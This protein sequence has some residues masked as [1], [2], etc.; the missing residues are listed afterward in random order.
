MAA[1]QK[2]K[3]A[4]DEARYFNREL[5]WLV[6]NT[7]VLEEALVE[8]TPLL[9]RLKFVAIVASNLDEFFMVRVGGLKLLAARNPRHRDFAGLSPAQQLDA[10]RE[11]AREQVGQ[12]DACYQN[13]LEPRLAAAGIRR[14][15]AAD[16]T[17]GQRAYAERFMQEEVLSVLTP[18]AVQD[19]QALPLLA[20]KRLHL[21][22]RLKAETESDA[23]KFAVIPISAAL[24]RFITL[25]STQDFEYILIEDLIA[26]FIELFFPGEK[27]M[28][29]VAFRPTR[30]AD[31]SVREDMAADLLSHMK[32]VLDARDTSDC[33]RLELDARAT[34]I[35]TRFLRQLLGVRDHDIYC[36]KGPLDL[37]AMMKIAGLGGY[38]MLRQEPWR[39]VLPV[40]TPEGANMFELLDRG[41]ILLYHPYDA[42][43]PVLRLLHQAADDP[44]VLAIKQILYRT[45]SNSQI[46]KALLRAA[47]NGKHVTALVE[48]KARFDEARNIDRARDLEHAGVQV[49]YGVKG[50]KTHAKLCLV[51][52]REPSGIARYLHLGTGNYNENTASLYSDVSFLVKDP[53]L[54][55]DAAMF[56]NAI[57]GYSQPQNYEKI[58]AAPT[59]LRDRLLQGIDTEI[60]FA[61]QG[62]AA[63]IWAKVN[64]LAD[65]VMI[66]KLYEASRAGVKIELNIRGICCLRPGVSGLSENIRVLSIIDRYLEHARIIYFHHGGEPRI[67]ISSADWM[68][69][70]LDRRIELLAP[71]EP[72]ECRQRLIRILKMHFSDNV[73]GRELQPDGS[74]RMP[75]MKKKGRRVQS[76]QVLHGE[77]EEASRKARQLETTVFEPHLPPTSAA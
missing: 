41:P 3:S 22:V 51:V 27:V 75:P 70:N 2:K 58:A 73:K 28:E 40:A 77:V 60:E 30:N 37:S 43:E 66:D 46:V 62:Q 53:I 50:Y 10:I 55:Q 42:F 16:L 65:P 36:L 63:R 76:Q 48:L 61:R 7:R 74:Y 14:R 68:P 19:G 31:M 52:R 24:S 71:V 13:D 11:R 72:P 17:S 39:P 64:S 47:H 54:G 4:R 20:G 6:F 44:D 5:S 57:T 34:R 67:Y 12:Q 35:L 21:C 9:D 23:W 8:E 32:E 25:P 38:D 18:M 59:G 29:C 33:V 49:V 1:A 69:R 56:F 45:S 26:E 15:R